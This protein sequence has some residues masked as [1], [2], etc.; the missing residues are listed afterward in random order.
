MHGIEALHARFVRHRFSNHAHDYFVIGLV[1]EGTQT[2]RYRGARQTTPSGAVFLVNAGESHTGEPATEYGYVYRTLYPNSTLLRLVIGDLPASNQTPYF[3]R[4][5][6]NDPKLFRMLQAFHRALGGNF[7][8]IETEAR[9]FSSLRLLLSRYSEF[10]NSQRQFR[11]ESTIA[12]RAREYLEANSDRN[13]SLTELAEVVARDVFYLA[14]I[15]EWEVGLPPHA[16]L[17]SVRITKSKQLLASGLSIASVAFAVGYADQ[18]HF[19]HRFK[20]LLGTTPGQ[21]QS[22][23]KIRQD[24]NETTNHPPAIVHRRNTNGASYS[25]AV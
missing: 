19:T 17:D 11:R 25:E 2:Y 6:L 24:K 12:H 23:H 1:E 9:L 21:Y 8:L 18:S 10:R 3:T 15:F 13:V 5:V 22:R 14:H 7:P 4:A 20:R 16:Y